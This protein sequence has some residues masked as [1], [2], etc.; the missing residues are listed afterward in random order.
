MLLLLHL[1]GHFT[2]FTF[3]TQIFREPVLTALL[4]RIVGELTERIS[5]KVVRRVLGQEKSQANKP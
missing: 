2:I 1:L 5:K 4:R 3:L